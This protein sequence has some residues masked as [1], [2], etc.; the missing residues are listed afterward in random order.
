MQEDSDKEEKEFKD[1]K[2]KLAKA[3]AGDLKDDDDLDDDDSDS[4]YEYTAGDLA[5]YDSALDNV[6]E[7][8]YIK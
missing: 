3:R 1:L 4:D 2:K 7:L 8:T 5:I 6:D